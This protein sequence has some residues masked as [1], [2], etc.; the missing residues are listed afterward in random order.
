VDFEELDYLFSRKAISKLSNN[1]KKVYK[2]GLLA[3]FITA[4]NV[5]NL[6]MKKVNYDGN[7]K[8]C[9]S[10]LDN[11]RNF[12]KVEFSNAVEDMIQEKLQLVF[13]KNPNSDTIVNKIIEM[14]REIIKANLDA[15]RYLLTYDDLEDLLDVK[16][17][18]I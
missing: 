4:L 9:H 15:T 11:P 12:I 8:F 13:V 16:S 10:V 18:L 2:N 3:I 7:I 5:G 1:P 17:L 14:M 6:N